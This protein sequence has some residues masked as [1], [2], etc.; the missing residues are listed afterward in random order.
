[1]R[2]VWERIGSIA[3]SVSERPADRQAVVE[4]EAALR[5][6]PDSRDRHRDLV[7]A[8]SRVGDLARAEQVAE[9]WLGRDELDPE[10]LVA[11]S[12][13]VGR[14][15]RR[16]EALRLLTG[17]VDLE[18]DSEAL[19]TRL[20]E[21]F[22][23]AG[24]A[25]RACSHRVAMAETEGADPDAIAE[26]VRCEQSL[27]DQASATQLLSAVTD[28]NIRRRVERAV[29]NPPRQRGVNGD[30]MLEATWSSPQDLDLTIVN[31]QGQ[32]ISWMGGRTNVVG[33][34]AWAPG[35][36]KLGLRWTPVGTYFIEVSRTD[37][38]DTTPV[39]GQ[40]SVRMLRERRT[41]PFTLVGQQARV[42]SVRV[43]R[44]SRLVPAGF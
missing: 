4:A 24:Q 36:E 29:A 41:I 43:R 22:D 40:I 1:M 6:Q 20:I 28:A 30:L 14:Q 42:G 15:G 16:A 12:D 10:A 3:T 25:N 9:Q 27:G 23:R 33:E 31:S 35:R 7:R 13:V 37:P 18:P 8:L 44:E 38:A 26:A 32:R 2:R 21:A 17:V 5:L 19:H 34:T 39:T 11:L